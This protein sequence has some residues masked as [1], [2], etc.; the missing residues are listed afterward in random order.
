MP[1]K[2]DLALGQNKETRFHEQVSHNSRTTASTEQEPWAQG[3]HLI[4]HSINNNQ[5]LTTEHSRNNSQS[6][7]MLTSSTF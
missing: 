6:S 5:I 7:D 4:N 2:Y 3:L 1:S